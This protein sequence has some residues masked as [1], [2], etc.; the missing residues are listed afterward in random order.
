M[1]FG[2]HFLVVKVGFRVNLKDLARRVR[3]VV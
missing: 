3:S 2:T 1:P